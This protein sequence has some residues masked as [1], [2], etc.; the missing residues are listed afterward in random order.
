VRPRGSTPPLTYDAAVT[1]KET[2][3]I[4]GLEAQAIHDA[5]DGLTDGDW[6]Q[7]TACAPWSV[8]D[9][10]GHLHVVIAWLPQ[11][12]AGEVPV[13]AGVTDAQYYRLDKRFSLSAN[14]RRIDLAVEHAA[15][16]SDAVQ[17]RAAFES[18]VEDVSDRCAREPDD[19]VVRTRHGD[20]M[21]LHHFLATRVVELTI[22][23]LDIARALGCDP[24][25]TP[26]AADFVR[27]LLLGQG[28]TAPIQ[29]WD[30]ITFLL[31]ATG[32]VP[33]TDDENRLLEKANVTWLTLG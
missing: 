29:G 10:L 32:R 7:P 23:G 13:E 33:V 30:T 24:W 31:K 18:L 27:S 12:L 9:M 2:L 19:R 15:S 14:A 22:H 5:M 25:I 6:D 17:Q 3:G 21:L 4:F 16:F 26:P 28:R 20:A 8:R 11:V 1:L